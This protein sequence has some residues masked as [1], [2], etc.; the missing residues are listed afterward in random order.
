MQVARSLALLSLAVAAGCGGG[1]GVAD[2]GADRPAAM[3]AASETAPC[4]VA[5]GA[6]PGECLVVL[7]SD[8]P[9]P[10]GLALD[11]SNVYWTQMAAA[12]FAVVRVAKSGGT[13]KVLLSTASPPV[14][15]GGANIYLNLADSVAAMRIPDE[16]SGIPYQGFGRGAAADA[17]DA[18]FASGCTGNASLVVAPLAGGPPTSLYGGVCPHDVVLDSTSVYWASSGGN[19]SESSY[20]EPAIM[21]AALG[22]GSMPTALLG[23]GSMLIQHGGGGGGAGGDT[24]GSGGATGGASGAGGE[25][26]DAGTAPAPLRLNIPYGIAVDATNV[27]WTDQGSYGAIP[28]DGAI[29]KMPLAGGAASTVISG[30]TGPSD[31]VLDGATFYWISTDGTIKKAPVTGG[32]TT[33]LASAQSNSRDIVVDATS[34]YW[35][36]VDDGAPTGAVVKLTPK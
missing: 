16:S 35:I 2:A 13:P 23:G 9:F 33:T 10:K 11:A 8:L 34:V 28:P 20:T 17:R 5:A 36:N 15:I 21:K 26:D 6:A 19:Q 22:G 32:P 4:A 27:Y 1:G 14:A 7:A 31:L 3:D 24:G 18:Y 30:L 25:A 29:V 12:N